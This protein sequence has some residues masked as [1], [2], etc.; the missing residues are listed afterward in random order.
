M[1]G[2]K[3]EM[4]FSKSMMRGFQGEGRSETWGLWRFEVTV[5]TIETRESKRTHQRYDGYF[6]LQQG[7]GVEVDID[8]DRIFVCG[9]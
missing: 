2:L 8:V 5:R 9:G 7:F 6:S 1:F 4:G 3:G